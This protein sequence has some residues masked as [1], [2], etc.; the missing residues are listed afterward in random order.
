MAITS[1]RKG[2]SVILLALQSS[3]K[4]VIWTDYQSVIKNMGIRIVGGTNIVNGDDN[5]FFQP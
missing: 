1:I 2:E 5:N 3:E 4:S